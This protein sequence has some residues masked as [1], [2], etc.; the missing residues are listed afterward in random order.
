MFTIQES[1][2]SWMM[3][4]VYHSGIRKIMSDMSV[5][6][7]FAIHTFTK[8]RM[9]YWQLYFLFSV[10]YERHGIV[11]RCM[12]SM[13]HCHFW[14]CTNIVHVPYGV[15]GY[16]WTCTV[17]HLSHCFSQLVLCLG[18]FPFVPYGHACTC[19]GMYRLSVRIFHFAALCS[20]GCIAYQFIS[21]VTSDQ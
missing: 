18:G 2:R 5:P 12:Q 8:L 21:V 6:D 9:M 17:V 15:L 4:D 11:Y 7:L 3:Y 1:M 20:I 19:T 14:T 13:Q 10:R 16:S